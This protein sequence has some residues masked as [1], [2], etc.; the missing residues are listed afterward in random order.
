[1]ARR[2]LA[3]VPPFTR[4]LVRWCEALLFSGLPGLLGLPG[5]AVVA[6]VAVV[7]LL[8]SRRRV[9]GGERR[10]CSLIP[11][12]AV[13]VGVA[14]ED[15]YSGD[16]VALMLA[17]R[18]WKRRAGRRAEMRDSMGSVGATRREMGGGA[19][20]SVAQGGENGL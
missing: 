7:G 14:E 2:L 12:V 9:A 11:V 13:V 1:M 3:K 15:G 6:V 4:T 8:P 10:G 18:G 5:L 19:G 16:V 17:T 20:C